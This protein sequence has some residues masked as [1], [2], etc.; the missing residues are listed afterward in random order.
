MRLRAALLLLALGAGTGAQAA[1]VHERIRQTARDV[2]RAFARYAFAL[3]GALQKRP[4]AQSSDLFPAFGATPRS[5]PGLAW[6]LTPASADQS[7]LCVVQSVSNVGDWNQT[8]VALDRAGLRAA[9]PAT[10][11]VRATQALAPAS[12]PAALA[13]VK[14]LDRRDV[15]S[16]TYLPTYPEISGVDAGAVTRAGLQ[17][18]ASQGPKAVTVYNPYIEVEPGVGLW[19]GVDGASSREG[20]SI[21]HS[22][23]WI[24]PAESCDVL[25]SYD[26][27]FG[28]A[29]AGQL[30][31]T[32]SNGAV[33]NIGLVG[34][35]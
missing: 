15:P 11:E 21:S 26:A 23:A 14:T 2:E 31:L 13:G 3:D 32:F 7:V 20:F 4:A 5:V 27:S 18:S 10:C 9:S 22:C 33:A 29:R 19:V 35:N 6:Y 25:V 28:D 8:L 16:P 30:R 12:F 34:L 24:A 1:P 17:V